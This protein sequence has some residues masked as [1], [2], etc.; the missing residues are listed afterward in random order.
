MS[1][2]SSKFLYVILLSTNFFTK[3]TANSKINSNALGISRGINGN[4]L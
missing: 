2:N 3:Q 4:D 1:E